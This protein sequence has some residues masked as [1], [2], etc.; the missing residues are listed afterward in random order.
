[1]NV[2]GG[3]PQGSPIIIPD[4]Q[5]VYSSYTGEL[6]GYG[7]TG[8]GVISDAPIGHPNYGKDFHVVEYNE[9]NGSYMAHYC[10]SPSLMNPTYFGYNNHNNYNFY[11]SAFYR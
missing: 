1:M 4:N 3:G 8:R 11:Q 9:V 5:P 2:P 6:I 10:P 7:P